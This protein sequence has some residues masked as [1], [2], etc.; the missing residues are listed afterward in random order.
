MNK[1]MI[2]R[3]LL[4]A[5]ASIC[6]HSTTAVASTDIDFTSI[7]SG[8][9]NNNGTML[10]TVSLH[11]VEVDLVVNEGTTI[12]VGGEE[13][14]FD[15][16]NID[17]F[18]RVETF[19]AA[20][21]IVAEEIKVLD[22]QKEEFRI[23]GI[24]Q[25][26]ANSEDDIILTVLN[27]DI[28]V[29]PGTDITR[30]GSRIGNNDSPTELQTGDVVNIFGLYDDMSLVARRIH[31]G[32]RPQGLIELEGK[33]ISVS[34]DNGTLLSITMLVGDAVVVT[35]MIDEN[36]FIGGTLEEDAFVEVRGHLDENFILL[37]FEIVVDEDGD[38]DADDDNSRGRG[39]GLGNNGGNDSDEGPELEIEAETSLTAVSGDLEGKAKVKYEQDGD[40]VE[41]EFEVEI[42]DASANSS[43]GIEIDFGATTVS[44]GNLSTDH[45]GKGEL[46]FSTSPDAGEEDLTSLIPTG[47]DVRDIT[48][49]RVYAGTTLVLEGSF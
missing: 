29:P 17:D 44:F 4:T 35:V 7:V 8:K 23:R 2:H 34:S 42:E 43:Y 20:E 14:T 37:G 38:G 15:D 39:K 45:E 32:N 6:I 18:V 31:V 10:V 16:L 26:T 33:I 47:S 13:A 1:G 12:E 24:V 9:T 11:G 30:R 46:E 3:W 49:I 48:A 5:V 36:T 19:L 21:G 41:Q 27:V 40:N 22:S 28:V 25:A